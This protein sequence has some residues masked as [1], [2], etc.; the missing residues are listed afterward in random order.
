MLFRNIIWFGRL[1]RGAGLDVHTGRLLDA[2]QAIE[3]VGLA[4]RDDVR[5]ALRALLVHRHEDLDRFDR[6]FDL[7]WRRR[8][9]DGPLTELHS[10]GDPPRRVSVRSTR[11]MATAVADSPDGSQNE[12]N[13]KSLDAAMRVY[14]PQEIRRRKDF[15]QYS[16]E[17][18]NDARAFLHALEFDVGWRRTR[19]WSAG[20]GRALD[21]GRLLRRNM[22]HGGE[23]LD[24]PR[25]R[26]TD[27]L[28]PLVLI[29]DISGSME[30]YTR[31][32]L[33]FVHA[34]SQS[35]RNIDAYLFATRLT[36][37][38]DY[39]K[40]EGADEV[41]SAIA[42][43]VP[44]WSGGTRIGEALK[45]FNR[46]WGRRALGHGPVVLLISDGW[47]RGDPAL[48]GAEIARLQRSCH[49]LIWLNPLLGRPGYEPLTRG[50]QVALKH[51]DDFL[52]AHNLASLESLADHL[53]RL[54]PA[55][56]V[57]RR[58]VED[59]HSWT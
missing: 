15:A 2:V 36:R 20:R 14:S 23:Y 10:L 12:Q 21:L 1:L 35:R 34:L 19:R 22:K 43:T 49:R 46:R 7:F 9:V 51:V 59:T 33:H 6:G 54:A 13:D 41:V 30:R 24:L 55:R 18:I 38:T 27:K 40:R 11:P 5:S 58:Y 29:C 25:R 28:R 57:R 4:R 50:M 53:N 17:E 56:P 3:H 44:D 31:M 48:L 26:R 45:T 37:V 39:L 16:E 42:R 52:P 8:A 47:D 32:L